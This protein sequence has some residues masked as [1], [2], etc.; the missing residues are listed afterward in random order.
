[1]PNAARFLRFGGER[2]RVE[3]G[4]TGGAFAEVGIDANLSPGLH[5]IRISSADSI[6]PD[7][8]AM[9]ML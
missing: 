4:E 9:R 8:D 6:V 7:I 1:M 5:S 2:R 3:V